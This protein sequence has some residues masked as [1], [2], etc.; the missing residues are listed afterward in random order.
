VVIVTFTTPKQTHDHR[1]QRHGHEHE[2][3]L[4]QTFDFL[5]TLEYEEGS[6]VDHLT[7]P[8]MAIRWIADRGLLHD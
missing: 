8:A 6:P 3:G 5:N 4:D 2:V 1:A 7:S